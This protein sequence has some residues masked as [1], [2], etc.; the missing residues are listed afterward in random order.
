MGNFKKFLE[1]YE[2]EPEQEQAPS[3]PST[4][5][6]VVLFLGEYN[7]INK[8]ELSR[9]KQFVNDFMPN[10]PEMFTERVDLG[11]VCDYN[12]SEETK[13]K[14]SINYN[15]SLLE[16]QFI[17]TRLFGLKLYPIQ[18]NSINQLLRLADTEDEFQE[19]REETGEIIEM[20]KENFVNSNVLVVVNPNDG[21]QINQ[22]GQIANLLSGEVNVGLMPYESKP[23]GIGEM[24]GN[25]PVSSSLIKAIVLMDAIRPDP[26]DLKHFSY[27]YKLQDHLETL[28]RIHFRTMNEH[29][30]EAF[31]MVFPEVSQVQEDEDTKHWNYRIMM[32]MLKEMYLKEEVV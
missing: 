7:P 25:V 2:V 4:K 22:V 8:E 13:L 5:W 23:T 19:L 15:L 12:E 18:L 21:F 26:E 20:F 32:Q 16:R 10:N 29:Y 17:S 14:D 9:V 30:V 6:G 28:K 27:M 11:L 1:S 31:R 3:I 24:L